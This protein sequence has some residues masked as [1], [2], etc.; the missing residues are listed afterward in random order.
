[1]SELRYDP[2]QRRWV[3]IATERSARPTDFRRRDATP[4]EVSN[5]AASCPFCPGNE[6]MTPHEILASRPGGGPNNSSGWDVRVVP[7]KYPALGIE[8]QLERRAVGIFDRMHGIGAHEVVIETPDHHGELATLPIDQVLRVLSVYQERLIDLKRD[9]RFRYILLFK[10]HGAAAGATL[11]HPH[12]QIIA[13]PVT[14]R[15][16]AVELETCKS[17]HQIKERCLFCD[18]IG[19]EAEARKRILIDSRHFLAFAPYASRFPYE[20]SILPKRHAFAYDGATGEE[21][22]DLAEVLRCS[23]SAIRIALGDVA[24]TLALHTAPNLLPIPGYWRTIREDFHWH[25]EIMPQILPEPGVQRS[26][27]L[28]VN[29]VAPETAIRRL[30][31]AERDSP[32]PR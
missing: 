26:S 30:Q 21:L 19:N 16:V 3:I 29:P 12:S 22:V 27:G 9:P 17:H 1:M 4:P 25:F 8:G 10:N 13:T 6:A 14:P 31:A 15:T 23:L 2:I 18:I 28:H 5:E 24:Y 7:N 11:S 20:L 32:V